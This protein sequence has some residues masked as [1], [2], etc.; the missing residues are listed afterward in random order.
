MRQRETDVSVLSLAKRS[1]NKRQSGTV[2]V[3]DVA[4]VSMTRDDVLILRMT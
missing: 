3:T 4:R 1:D 2:A